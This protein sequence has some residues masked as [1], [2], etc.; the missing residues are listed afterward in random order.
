MPEPELRAV[1]FDMDGTLLD[2][3]RLW[4][5][6]LRDLAGELGRTLDPATRARL[7]GMD[8]TESV[9]VLHSEW[10]L[11]HDTVPANTRWL[12]ER[13]K[14]LFAAGMT[15]RP[16]A[17]DLLADVRRSGIPAALVTATGRELVDIIIGTIGASNFTV[18]VCGDEVARNKP[19]PEPYATAYRALGL[20]PGDCL[21]IED[22]V[23]GVASASAAGVPVLAV[24]SEVSIP[25]RPGVA[26][27]ESL[28]G[29]DVAALRRAHAGLM[30][31]ES[32]IG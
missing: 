18:T 28:R 27:S 22:S 4:E 20:D 26:V 12:I 19:D 29:V 9:E 14:V 1:L 32:P 2:S 21:A 31:R 25:A 7:V 17:A 16:G 24:P 13:M 11:P 30:T 23:T 10:G 6:G 5:V 3:E 8:Q 15:W